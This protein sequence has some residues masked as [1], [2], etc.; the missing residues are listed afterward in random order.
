MTTFHLVEP[1][2][3]A[4]DIGSVIEAAKLVVSRKLTQLGTTG[5]IRC[6][7]CQASQGQLFG[8]FEGAT[9]Y[10]DHYS[11]PIGALDAAIKAYEGEGN[12]KVSFDIDAELRK[13]GLD[14]DNLPPIPYQ[15]IGRPRYVPEFVIKADCG[16]CGDKD[17]ITYAFEHLPDGT[18]NGVCPT[19]GCDAILTF[20]PH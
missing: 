14:P 7:D 16:W 8:H 17:L 9:R 15:E 2:E 12:V 3:P 5:E 11:C 20:T 1:A 6:A 13:E 4:I 10:G 18:Y 19:D